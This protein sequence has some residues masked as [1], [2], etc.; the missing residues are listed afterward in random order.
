MNEHLQPQLD[1]ALTAL[2]SAGFEHFQAKV[3]EDTHDEMNIFQNQVNLFR[4]VAKTEVH[5][6]GI[7]QGRKATRGMTLSSDTD[8]LMVASEL[9]V[10]ALEA[11]VDENHQ[12]SKGVVHDHVEGPLEADKALMASR[13]QELFAHREAAHPKVSLNQGVVSHKRKQSVLGSSGGSVLRTD[14]GWYE[15]FVL[16]VGREDEKLSSMSYIGGTCHDLDQPLHTR[17]HT[18]DL[19][20][21]AAKQIHTE[22][23]EDSFRGTALFN[24][25]TVLT[26]LDFLVGQLG[27]QTLLT[28]S[29]MYADKVGE[30]VA[31]TGLSIRHCASG[32]GKEPHTGRGYLCEDFDLV[33]DGRLQ[34]L[35]ASDYASRKLDLPHRPSGSVY[36]IA[37]GNTPKDQLLQEIE[38]GALIGRLSMGRPSANGDFSGVIKNSFL[39]EN[40]VQ[41]PAL[42][43]T[44]MTGNI[45]EMLLNIDGI[46]VET[47]Q[48]GIG[49]APWLRIPGLMFS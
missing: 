23:L 36:A 5:L 39:I 46:S 6:T 2:Q 16:V 7:V 32:P 22:R 13:I 30:L 35:L 48:Q 21:S 27:D 20:A 17:F 43:D 4:T 38:R 28:N 18:D 37:P 11:P 40:G 10:D 9:F 47:L 26:L 42:K 41:G 33:T 3:V 31:A 8:L 49:E 1:A 29:S 45:R 44:M 19:L 24:P 15:S 25:L 14:M 12:V 34:T